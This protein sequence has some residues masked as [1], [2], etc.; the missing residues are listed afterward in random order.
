M[1]AAELR[2]HLLTLRGPEDRPRMTWF[3]IHQETVPER[4]RDQVSIA[5]VWKIA[6]RPP[7][8]PQDLAI[9]HILGLN[10][11]AQV[12]YLDGRQRPRAQAVGAVPCACGQ[13]YVSNHPRRGRCFVCSPYRG[14]RKEQ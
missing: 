4:H 11:E 1:I 3:Q 9:R 5:T 13:W 7:Y 10:G 2:R 6:M 12:Q 8:E 14:R